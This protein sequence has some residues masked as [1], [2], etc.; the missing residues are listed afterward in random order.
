[1][2]VCVCVCVCMCV[3]RGVVSQCSVVVASRGAGSSNSSSDGSVWRSPGIDPGTTASSSSPQRPT[4]TRPFHPPP[5]ALGGRPPLAQPLSLS[6]TAPVRA[7]ALWSS[8]L[9]TCTNK[10]CIQSVRVCKGLKRTCS[11]VEMEKNDF[12]GRSRDAVF[13]RR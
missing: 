7:I 3:L 4:Q 6:R 10:A 9:S 12:K 1:V 2:C 8:S 11:T 5:Q 13:R